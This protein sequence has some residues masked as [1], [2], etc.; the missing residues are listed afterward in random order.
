MVLRTRIALAL[1]SIS[2]IGL[3]ITLMRVLALRFWSHLAAMVISVALLGFGLSGTVLTV[4][5]SRLRPQRQWWLS[6]LGLASA[7]SILV[8][9]WAVQKIP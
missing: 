9:S 8:C 1:I 6:L 4:L 3:E 2:V 5:Q 7:L